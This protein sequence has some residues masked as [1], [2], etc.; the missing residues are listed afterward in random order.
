MKVGDKVASAIGARASG[1]STFWENKIEQYKIHEN[2]WIVFV[3]E[4][5]KI[6]E[7]DKEKIHEDHIFQNIKKML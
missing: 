5:V 6:T 3:P 4:D 1:R 7:F 2:E